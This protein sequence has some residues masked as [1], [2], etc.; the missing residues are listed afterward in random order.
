MSLCDVCG[1]SAGWCGVTRIRE[2]SCSGRGGVG[3]D[4]VMKAHVGRAKLLLSRRS[5]EPSW[6]SAGASP[7][8][9]CRY[10]SRIRCRFAV[11][12]SPS[13]PTP[14]PR[15]GGEGSMLCFLMVMKPHIGRA[16]LLLSRRSFE[17][18][19]GSAG[20]SPSQDCG[21][22]PRIRCRFAV[23]LSPSPPTPLPRSGGAGRIFV[24]SWQL[25]AT[26]GLF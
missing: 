6:G 2:G 24:F 8:Q 1:S 23:G 9:E 3:G 12:L 25:V 20:A 13:P 4:M 16:K 5:F 10:G 18:S 7:S 19:W 22:G 26:G 17:P 21:Y 15:S 14:L 11:G